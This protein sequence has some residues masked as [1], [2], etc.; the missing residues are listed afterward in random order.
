MMTMM[1]SRMRSGV[2]VAPRGGGV[3]GESEA[4][5]VSEVS[6]ERQV[7]LAH[8]ELMGSMGSMQIQG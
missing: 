8:R 7:L 6:E 4:S 5:E 2:P 3:H 1:A